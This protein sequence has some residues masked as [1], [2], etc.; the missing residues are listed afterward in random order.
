EQLPADASARAIFAHCTDGVDLG[1]KNHVPEPILDFMHMHHGS[2]LLEYFWHK[3]Q[4]LGNP[5]GLSERDF[6]YPGIP[7]Q[8]KETAILAVGDPAAAHRSAARLRRRPPPAHQA[9]RRAG[10]A[11]R[12]PLSRTS[13]GS[14][15]RGCPA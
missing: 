15:R 3:N 9:R 8:T 12:P 11:P 10:R 2:G 14:L 5:K 1:R 6:R 4:E 13:T 7:P